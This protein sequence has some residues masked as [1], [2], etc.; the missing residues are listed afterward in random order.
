MRANGATVDTI[1]GTHHFGIL[2]ES[3]LKAL[4][5]SPSVVLAA[6]GNGDASMPSAA[7]QV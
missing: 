3:W 1:S 6:S 5:K 7:E 2:I 4:W